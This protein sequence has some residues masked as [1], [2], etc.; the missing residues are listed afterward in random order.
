LAQSGRLEV[1]GLSVDE[2][3]ALAAPI[4]K[5]FSAPWLRHGAEVHVVD[6]ERRVERKPADEELATEIFA[7]TH[8]EYV[9]GQTTVPAAA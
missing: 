5:K 1:G 8:D 7:N 3:N 2:F 6:P 9:R 4:E